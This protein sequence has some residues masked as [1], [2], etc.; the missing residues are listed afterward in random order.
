[1][2]SFDYGGGGT[3]SALN[4]TEDL[5]VGSLVRGRLEGLARGGK[6]WSEFCSALVSEAM[7]VRLTKQ[8]SKCVLSSEI[9]N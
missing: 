8:T 9:F 4:D 6:N 3:Q 5:A 2:I 7:G 1:M